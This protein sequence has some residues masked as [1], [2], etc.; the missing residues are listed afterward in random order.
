M[1]A[2]FPPPP[3]EVSDELDTLFQEY[4]YPALE[5]GLDQAHKYFEDCKAP[6]E[7]WLFSFITRFQAKQWLYKNGLEN[8]GFQLR[9]LAMSGIWL[10]NA[11]YKIRIWKEEW[12]TDPDTHE[13]IAAINP[14][15]TGSRH[16]YFEQPQLELELGDGQGVFWAQTKLIATWGIDNQRQLKTLDLI[17]PSAFDDDLKKVD[18]HWRTSLPRRSESASDFGMTGE[19]GELLEDLD[20]GND[21]QADYDANSR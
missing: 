11:R 2:K 10:E 8:T 3:D 9:E 1:K 21:S 7:P 6:I 4:I 12:K 18:V 13:L 15:T 17:C 19:V 5:H 14:G 16:R 20:Y